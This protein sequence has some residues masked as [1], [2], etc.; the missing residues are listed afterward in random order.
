MDENN[1]IEQRY[2]TITYHSEGHTS[3]EVPVDNN[4]YKIPIQDPI[5]FYVALDEA[6]ILDK[7][8]L[9]KTGYYFY[10]WKVR[11]DHGDMFLYYFP[12]KKI[13]IAENLDLDATWNESDK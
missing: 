8:T 10:G 13:Y 12:N 9:E 11:Q 6:I 5:S 2:L 3:G 1:T 7:G 4:K